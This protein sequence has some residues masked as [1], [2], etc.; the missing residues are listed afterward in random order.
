MVRVLVTEPE[1]RKAEAVFKAASE[2]LALRC[3]PAPATEAD[4]A[5]AIVRTGA[6]HV[7]VGVERYGDALYSAL[8]RGSVIARFGVGHDGIDKT[9][10][11]AAGLVVSNT[12]GALN[13]SVAE[14][15][16][17]LLASAA[18]HLPVSV[19]QVRAGQ[20]IPV[21]GSEL[22]EKRLAI[23]GCGAIGCLVARIAARGFRMKVTACGRSQ[24]DANLLREEFGIEDYATD[25]ASAVRQADFVSLHMPATSENRHFIDAKRLAHFSSRAWLINTAR[26]MVVD[27]TAL[28]DALAAG[29]LGGAA[30]DVFENEP[31]VPVS[32]D[33]DLRR[34]PGVIMTP[35]I[36]SS[37]HE[38]CVR[39]AERALANV[40]AGQR[41]DYT[42][43]D[44]VNRDVLAVL[45][46]RSNS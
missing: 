24:R 19:A 34:L 37:T 27:E 39:M 12:P 33:R 32:P 8:E 17:A 3:E 13:D 5:D 40:A 31:Y 42:A 25:F 14:L 7:I 4:L 23:V 22:R 43:M 16:M 36:G 45:S 28:Y 20:W 15:T 10:A 1:Y 9:R 38:A 35:H 44:L 21:I 29:R 18:R 30:L 46:N 41:G 11:T 2:I 6:R 26:G